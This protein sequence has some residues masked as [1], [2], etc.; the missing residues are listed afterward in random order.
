MAKTT[1]DKK[2]KQA[3]P[4]LTAEGR[5][6]QMIALAVDLAE[7]QLRE[8]TASSQVITHFLKLGSTRERLEQEILEEQKKLVQ[9]KTENL[10]S[11]K[12]QEELYNKALAAMTSYKTDS[13][14]SSYEED[15]DD[16][17]HNK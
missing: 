2:T 14:D 13:D 7:K 4:A 11:M 5:E 8:G 6:N 15:V 1:K 12:K 3:R 16:G 9:A 10:E 17:D